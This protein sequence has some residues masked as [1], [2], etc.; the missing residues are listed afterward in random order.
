MAASPQ[1]W[2]VLQGIQWVL[3]NELLVVPAGGGS[4]VNPFST[5]TTTPNINNPGGISDQTRYGTN[6][7]GTITNAIYIGIPKNVDTTYLAQCHLVASQ[8]TAERYAHGGKIRV[9]HTVL[10]RCLFN[11]NDHSKD[12]LTQTNN[13]YNTAD[14]VRVL[15]NKHAMLAVA[16]APT[17]IASKEDAGYHGYF[18]NEL[19]GYSWIGWQTA[20]LV[21]EEFNITGGIVS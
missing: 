3:Q 6:P 14:A 10:I 1:T 2:A 13:A 12:W 19:D 7:N 8:E 20:A 21:T 16:Y 9:H 18:Y 11:A 5:F 17:V 4:A 15:I